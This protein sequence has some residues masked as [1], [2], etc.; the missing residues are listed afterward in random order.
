MLKTL[1]IV[2]QGAGGDLIGAIKGV[3]LITITGGP[4]IVATDILETVGCKLPELA[5]ATLLRVEEAIGSDNPPVIL[6]N[7]LDLAASGFEAP[8]YGQCAAALAADPQVDA[9][10]AI[11]CQHRNWSFPTAELIKVQAACRKPLVA[12]YIGESQVVAEERL[13]LHEAGIP[14]YHSIAAAAKGFGAL[15]FYSGR[16]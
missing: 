16:G 12:C 3:G 6:R 8:I 9:L 13:R 10:L 11:Y 4:A 15:K 2:K 1:S 14:L 5:A 7:P